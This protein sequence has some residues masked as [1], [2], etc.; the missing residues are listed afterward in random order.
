M[1]NL[2][3]LIQTGQYMFINLTVKNTISQLHH[4]P[5]LVILATKKGERENKYMGSF[6][7]G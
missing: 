7:N 5:Q 6:E 2:F 1:L 4:T 3:T